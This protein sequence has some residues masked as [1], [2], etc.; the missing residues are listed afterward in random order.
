MAKKT[1]HEVLFC[2]AKPEL[3]QAVRELAEEENRPVSNMIETIIQRYMESI[4][5]L[6]KENRLDQPKIS[7]AA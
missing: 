2:R 6:P 4:G 7:E 3:A 1:P 5:K